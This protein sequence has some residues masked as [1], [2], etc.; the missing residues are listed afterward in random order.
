MALI[1]A[2][3]N[4]GVILS[5]GGSV[6]IGISSPSLPHF[7]TPF[8]QSLIGLIV[9]ADVKQHVYITNA[10]ELRSCVKVQVAVLGS[11]SPN[12]PYGLCGRKATLN[13]NSDT[14]SAGAVRKS[15]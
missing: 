15:R 1:A 2:H 4:A 7:H 6:A 14:Q 3:L 12:D 8:S 9:S 5:G 10:A 11:P 13:L